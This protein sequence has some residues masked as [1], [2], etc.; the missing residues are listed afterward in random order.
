MLLFHLAQWHTLAKLQLHTECSVGM[1]EQATRLLGQQLQKFQDYTCSLFHTT[2]LPSETAAHWRRT[3]VKLKEKAGG[4][5]EKPRSR[6]SMSSTPH[7]KTFN[8]S[9]YKIH[10]LGHYADTIRTLGTTDLYT[11]QIVSSLSIPLV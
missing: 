6:P 3:E 8:L 7:P 5:S 1:L 11:T 4:M 10:A 2:E 9:T